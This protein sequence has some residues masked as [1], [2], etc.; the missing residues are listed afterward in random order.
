MPPCESDNAPDSLLDQCF[1]YVARHLSIISHVDKET[2]C[3]KLNPGLALPRELC[4]KII[5]FYSQNVGVI[6][7]R[8]ISLFS[9]PSVTSLK[10]VCLRHSSI[11]DEG[12]DALLKHNLVEL[13]LE[14][15]FNVTEKSLCALNEHGE[16]LTSLSVGAGVRLLPLINTYPPPLSSSL[17]NGAVIKAPNLRKLVLRNFSPDVRDPIYFNTLFQNLHHLTH[18]DLSGYTDIEDFSF[19][20]PLTKVVSLVLHNVVKVQDGLETIYELKSLRHLDIS[21]SNDK[22]R[23]FVMEHSTLRFIL[24]NLPDL[25]SLDISGTNLAGTG[26]AVIEYSEGKR[27]DIPG[28]DNR[29][30]NPLEFLG[31]YGTQHGA[32]RRHDIPAKLISGD[33]NE[34][35]ILIAA[36]AYIHRPEILQRVLNDLYHLFRYEHCTNIFRALNVVLESMERH[37]S[38]KH[39]QISGSATLFYIV[40]NKDIPPFPAKVKRKIITTLLNS[41]NTH[42]EDDTMMRNGCLTLCQFKIPQDVL[43]EYE[44]LVMMLLHIVS[45][46]QQEG[47]VQRIGIYL[48]NSLACQVDNQQ[49]QLLGDLC[50]IDRMLKLI[51]D[52]VSQEVCDDVLEVAW[53]TM[54]NV[55]D[56]TAIN[57][58]RFLDGGGMELFLKCL[59]L[60]PEREELMRNMMGL[61]GNVAEV[62]HLRGRLMVRRYIQV[63]SELVNS[64]SDGIEVSYN[65]AGVLSH[66]ASDGEAAWRKGC[67]D[68]EVVLSNMVVAIDKWS[69]ETE[70]NINYRSFEPILQLARVRHTPQCQ[71]WAVWALAN[72]TKVY[73]DK[74]C[75]LVEAEGGVE[76]LK[77]LILDDSPYEKTKELAHLVLEHC[78]KF[79]EDGHVEMETPELDG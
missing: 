52:R 16:S 28:L 47:F 5:Y 26:V 19:L 45:S 11:T 44:R 61:L 74:Y 36:A 75:T 73:P 76:I 17:I 71:H 29:I 67:P 20:K 53:S 68:R 33:A 10:R 32:C 66:L 6:D 70:R 9:D 23:T 63:F 64:V 58:E 79:K 65:A 37:I 41:M 48:L 22:V 39:I 8:I 21:Q 25:V 1:V 31:L 54:W 30:D 12:L 43:F 50:A 46:M 35:Q 78:R 15:C 56:E 55:T 27:C 77:E 18:L 13:D 4:E 14:K 69:L 72:L 62:K 59:N 2:Q 7:D 3:F 60:F 24:T 49:K 42:Q 51:R 34:Q 40:K 38:E 57:C